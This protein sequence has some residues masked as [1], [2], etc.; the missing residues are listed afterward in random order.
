MQFD[1]AIQAKNNESHRL[2]KSLENHQWFIQAYDAEYRYFSTIDPD[3]L[4]PVQKLR[5]QGIPN[6]ITREQNECERL[7]RLITKIYWD[8]K[9]LEYERDSQQDSQE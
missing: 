2:S 7:S 6:W 9:V 3:T 5:L 1:K 8:I 4:D